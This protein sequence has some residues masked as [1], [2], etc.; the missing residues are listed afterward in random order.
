MGVMEC[1]SA[2][3]VWRGYEYYKEGKVH[4]LKEI[5]DGVFSAEVSGSAD[6]P[7]SVT[8]NVAHARKSLCDCPHAKKS[9][10]I[11]CKHMAATFFAVFPDKAESFYRDVVEER[12][13]AEREAEELYEKVVKYVS[14]M[15]K[16]QLVNELLGMLFEGPEWQLDRFAYE[17]GLK[18][19]R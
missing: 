7:Y 6:T 18:E 12:E 15:K 9:S 17:N 13:E 5:A 3:S 1:A 19:Y 10:N 14:H 16:E 4:N 11:V 2:A 8:L